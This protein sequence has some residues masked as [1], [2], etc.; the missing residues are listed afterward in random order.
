MLK[1]TT[2][3]GGAYKN[4]QSFSLFIFSYL[5]LDMIREI[6]FREPVNGVGIIGILKVSLLLIGLCYFTQ[7]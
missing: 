1:G 7:L 4:S 2:D 3:V 5:I 6:H